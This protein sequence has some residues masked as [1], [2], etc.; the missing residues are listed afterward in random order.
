[1]E[2]TYEIIK[3]TTG[4]YKG[5]V[6][7]INRLSK[8]DKIRN[9]SQNELNE[10]NKKYPKINQNLPL[11]IEVGENISRLSIFAMDLKKNGEPKFTKLIKLK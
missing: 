6:N 5:G 10:F 8:G 11:F 9:I 7:S 3:T 2:K 1:M 4:Y